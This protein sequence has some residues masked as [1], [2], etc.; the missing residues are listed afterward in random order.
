M[1]R[2][3]AAAPL[4]RP[5]PRVPVAPLAPARRRN[6]LHATVGTQHTSYNHLITGDLA[7]IGRVH[8][9]GLGPD[10]GD[11]QDAHILTQLDADANMGAKK[12][13]ARRKGPFKASRGPSRIMDRSAHVMYR[14]RGHTIEITIRRGITDKEFDI[15]IGKLKAHRMG[16]MSSVL[17]IIL[18]QK[19]K[20]GHIDKIDYEKLRMKISNE[21]EKKATIGLLLVDTKG[22]GPLQVGD[23]H[24]FDGKTHSGQLPF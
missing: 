6:D 20:L 9:V 4:G 5:P 10:V 11:E 18:R 22:K 1:P 12:L 16:A 17:Y 2:R 19:K 7:P 24:T 23:Y 3:R 8:L 21:L 13:L 15:L 14:R